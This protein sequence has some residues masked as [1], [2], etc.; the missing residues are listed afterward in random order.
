MPEPGSK[1]PI[2]AFVAA[3][4]DLLPQ[5]MPQR[6]LLEVDFMLVFVPDGWYLGL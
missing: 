6:Q 1:M 2:T 4:N 5:R 3:M